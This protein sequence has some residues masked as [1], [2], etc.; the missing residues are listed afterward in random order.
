MNPFTERVA[1]LLPNQYHKHALEVDS[2]LR[3]LGTPLGTVYALGDCATIE[4]RLVDHLLD[5]V[6]KC[7]DN[8]DGK[9]DQREFE[10]MMRIV[11]RKFPT[12]QVQVDKIRSVLYL[13]LRNHFALTYV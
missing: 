12:A 13:I 4:T 3:V 2:H 1:A 5:I 7:D 9:I 6:E 8:K 11:K 10:H